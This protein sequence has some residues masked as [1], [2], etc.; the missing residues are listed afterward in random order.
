MGG[1]HAA[2]TVARHAGYYTPPSVENP[3]PEVFKI[4]VPGLVGF[5]EGSIF[6]LAFSALPQ[7]SCQSKN[8]KG[9]GWKIQFEN[10]IKDRISVHYC[11]KVGKSASQEWFLGDQRVCNS[12]N[13][14]WNGVPACKVVASCR[15]LCVLLFKVMITTFFTPSNTHTRTSL[16]RNK[17]NKL[18]NRMT[19]APDDLKGCSGNVSAV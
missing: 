6:D 16:P 5:W 9:G 8:E 14:F 10:F 2:R 19:D 7:Y 13:T 11:W 17:W 1:G 3:A 15:D 18:L 4:Q 12:H